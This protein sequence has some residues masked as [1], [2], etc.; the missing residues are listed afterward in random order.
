MNGLLS[1]SSGRRSWGV[2]LGSWF[3]GVYITVTVDI[4][5]LTV[6]GSLRWALASALCWLMNKQVDPVVALLVS[7]M[8]GSGS[9]P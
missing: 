3:W 9:G 1:F 8:A 2:L 4:A 6:D 7:A 5:D